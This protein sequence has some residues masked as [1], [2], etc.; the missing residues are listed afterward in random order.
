MACARYE[1]ALPSSRTRP[2]PRPDGA[3]SVGLIATTLASCPLAWWLG[4]TGLSGGLGLGCRRP[5]RWPARCM[6]HAVGDARAGSRRWPGR[7]CSST[8][9]ARSPRRGPGGSRCRTAWWSD[10]SWR[11][12]RRCWRCGGPRRRG[13]WWGCVGA[14]PRVAPPPPRAPQLPLLNTPHAFAGAPAGDTLTMALLD[15][16]V[17]DARDPA[18]QGPGAALPEGPGHAGRGRCRRFIPGFA[19]GD[20]AASPHVAPGHARPRARRA[21]ARARPAAVRAGSSRCCSAS[22]GARLGA[23]AGTLAPYIGVHFVASPLS[24]VVT[25]A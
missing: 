11:R 4:T 19:G 12:P 10:R 8:V 6:A 16:V 5:W 3:V 22:A 20:V 1:Y 23:L 14:A 13:G 25:M 7:A 21:A 9:A 24:E 15:L 17:G 2:A 18:S